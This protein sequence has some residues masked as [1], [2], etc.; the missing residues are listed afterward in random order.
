[1]RVFT[2]EQVARHLGM[3]PD[4][5]E[6]LTEAGILPGPGCSTFFSRRQEDDD[7]RWS[8][9]DLGLLK[10]AANGRLVAPKA[11]G[12]SRRHNG[13]M[14]PPGVDQR[15]LRLRMRTPGREQ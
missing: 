3:D 13:A 7:G 6:A 5:L 14:P 12:L 15:N 10:R 9:A 4:D 1:M 2:T 8:E 11:S